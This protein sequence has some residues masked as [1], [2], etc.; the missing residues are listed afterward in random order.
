M[1]NKKAHQQ[2][3]LGEAVN[4]LASLLPIKGPTRAYIQSLFQIDRL[5]DTI[6]VEKLHSTAM[7]YLDLGDASY[8]PSAGCEP[9][10]RTH[11][12]VLESEEAQ[13]IFQQLDLD[14]TGTFSLP[15]IVCGLEILF[16][17]SGSDL[18]DI[19]KQLVRAFFHSLSLQTPRIC[20]S[21]SLYFR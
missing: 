9:Q 20:L 14:R 13:H 19:F 17:D 10:L 11:L 1:T 6:S 16:E 4:L 7:A 8:K 5:G 12:G 21:F 3:A 2:L 15:R 18:S